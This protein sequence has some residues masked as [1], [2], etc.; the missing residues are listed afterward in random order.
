M[1]FSQAILQNLKNVALL[2]QK[3][4]SGDEIIPPGLK[5]PKKSRLNRV[6]VNFETKFGMIGS[7]ILGIYWKKYFLR[8]TDSLEIKTVSLNFL[9]DIYKK[10]SWENSYKILFL[11]II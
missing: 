4:D 5:S 6:N 8:L 3:L 11:S 9:Y 2:E 10:L 1:E 7:Q